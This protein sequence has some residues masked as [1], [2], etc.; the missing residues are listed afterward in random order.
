MSAGMDTYV[1]SSDYYP[2]VQT[3]DF[4]I[5]AVGEMEPPLRANREFWFRNR[6]TVIE[7]LTKIRTGEGLE[8]IEAWSREKKGTRKYVVKDGFHRFYLTVAIGYCK[9]PIKVDDLDFECGS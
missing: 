1:R 4:E 7:A 9:L 5:V 6:D 8:P 3:I 2:T